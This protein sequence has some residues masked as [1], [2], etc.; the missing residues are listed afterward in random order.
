MATVQV[1]IKITEMNPA[2]PPPL[3]VDASGVPATATAG[4][5]FSGVIKA[6]GGTPPYT[7]AAASGSLPKGLTLDSVAGTITGTPDGSDVPA[8]T[9]VV[10]DEV[11]NVS[12][13]GK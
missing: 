7:F 2:P 12:D 9:S 13:S 10:F 5:A 6:S 11:I 3:A 1:D 4:A 8:G